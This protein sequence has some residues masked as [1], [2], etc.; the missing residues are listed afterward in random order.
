MTTRSASPGCL[1]P[2]AHPST[3]QDSLRPQV[4]EGPRFH[5]GRRRASGRGSCTRLA[6]WW[7]PLLPRSAGAERR[8]GFGDSPCSNSPDDLAGSGGGLLGVSKDRGEGSAVVVVLPRRRRVS[9]RNRPMTTCC[10][11]ALSEQTNHTDRVA[12][13][14]TAEPRPRTHTEHAH[15]T[16]SHRATRP[17]QIGTYAL[18]VLDAQNAGSVLGSAAGWPVVLCAQRRARPARNG[19]YAPETSAVGHCD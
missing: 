17:R 7:A 6:M 5:S 12:R 1:P 10:D 9:S 11:F 4:H 16:P 15:I 13:P 14:E 18:V 2:V 8:S 3:V 19:Q